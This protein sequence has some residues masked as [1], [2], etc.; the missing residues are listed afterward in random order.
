MLKDYLGRRKG[1]EETEE[2]MELEASVLNSRQREER[3]EGVMEGEEVGWSIKLR[4]RKKKG[5]RNR[6][7]EIERE[8]REQEGGKDDVFIPT[9]R[10]DWRNFESRSEIIS[11]SIRGGVSESVRKVE[12]EKKN[13]A[14]RTG[15]ADLSRR[16]ETDGSWAV[17]RLREVKT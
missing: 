17:L 7:S 2:E 9:S 12:R 16:T 13:D 3:G 11:S 5:A 1:G 4:L 14:S 15:L 8:K 6:V 10:R